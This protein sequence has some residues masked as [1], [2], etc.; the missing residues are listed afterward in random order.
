MKT[1]LNFLYLILLISLACKSSQTSV[2]DNKID[3][4]R[5]VYWHYVYISFLNIEE[6]LFKFRLKSRSSSVET[7]SFKKYEYDLWYYLSGGKKFAVGPFN[8][9]D[10]AENSNKIY[11][12]SNKKLDE[13]SVYPSNNEVFWFV[14]K[15]IKRERSNS[16]ELVRIPG[17]IASGS[18]KEFE[19]FF[20]ENL[21]LGIL[22]IGPFKQMSDAEESKRI[23]RLH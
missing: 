17:A 20:K 14:L 19:T 18:Y 23:Y 11:T 8:S 10:E 4:N 15:V 13:N 9:K 22:T 5:T 6:D 3:E 1:P 12:R 21:E 2:S 7:G 16:Y